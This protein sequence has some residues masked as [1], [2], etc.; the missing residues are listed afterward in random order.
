VPEQTGSAA[1]PEGV[2][3]DVK[4]FAIHDGP[5]IRTTVFLKGCP[6]RCLWC[7]NP[8]GISPSIELAYDPRQCIGCGACAAACPEGAHTIVGG[9]HVY[10]RSLCRACGECTRRC[11]T[12]ALRLV[13]RR[14]PVGEVLEIVLRDRIFYEKSG[15]GVTLSGG[16]AMAQPEFARAVLAAARAEGLHT[17]VDTSG[18]VP[19]EH[20]ECVLP[21]VDI[22]LYDVKDTDPERHRANTSGELGLVLDNLARLDAA[23]ARLHLRYPVIPGIN[24]GTADMRE[25]A[26]LWGTLWSRPPVELLPYHRLGE[27]K[28]SSL[29]RPAWQVADSTPQGHELAH[30]ADCLGAYGVEAVRLPEA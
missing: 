3:F 19:W 6:L 14:V 25:L 28:R 1:Q 4:R 10:E 9:Q 22:F 21:M 18:H 7:Q 16:E 15:G 20:F 12:E 27:G 2:I 8:E 24:D 30:M 13:G 11:P 5:G 17:C 26:G 29:G 23:G